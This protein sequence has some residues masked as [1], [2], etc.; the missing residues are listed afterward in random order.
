MS[1]SLQPCGACQASL[2]FTISRMEFTQVHVHWIS[3][4]IQPAHPLLPSSPFAFNLSQPQSVSVCWLFPSG[5]Q[6]IGASASATVLAMTIQSLFPLGLTNLIGAPLQYSC[7]EN[8]MDRRAWKA[9]V[10]GVA[11]GR[12]RLSNFTFTFH[13]QALEKE[14][15][16][17]FSVLAWRIP[18]IGEPGGLPVRP[19]CATP[20]TDT[21]EVT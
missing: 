8:P 12:T 5:S 16:T 15:A 13:F 19:A 2:S 7:L 10:H 6:S 18:G 21:T 14:M 1:D 20:E 3:D 11:E 17:H 9:A 4:A